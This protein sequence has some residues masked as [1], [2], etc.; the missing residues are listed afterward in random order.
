MGQFDFRENWN[1]RFGKT[2]SDQD[3]F[4]GQ[5]L[6]G[7]K[8]NPLI[9]ELDEFKTG[10]SEKEVPEGWQDPLTA[11]I[12]TSSSLSGSINTPEGTCVTS[13]DCPSGYSCIGDSCV[14]TDVYVDFGSGSNTPGNCEIEDDEGNPV[15]DVPFKCGDGGRTS[16]SN[17]GTCG[18]GQEEVAA[19]WYNSGWKA[20]Y[21]IYG[22]GCCNNPSRGI[23]IAIDEQGNRKKVKYCGPSGT[24]VG[25][26]PYCTLAAYYG[27]GADGCD[28]KACDVP[29]ES[30]LAGTCYQSSWPCFCPG[31]DPCP[32]CWQCGA[33]G[34]TNNCG[35]R[36][37]D[38]SKIDG[39]KKKVKYDCQCDCG[40]APIEIEGVGDTYDEAQANASDACNAKCEGGEADCFNYCRI[41]CHCNA[42]CP[43]GTCG[44]D[45]RCA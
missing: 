27:R 4:G 9:K 37:A 14:R 21:S 28:G 19:K 29:C 2:T 1:S 7:S 15:A 8:D 12:N 17:G 18:E 25:C 5:S 34:D 20:I 40:Q 42:D 11:D 3:E 13:T 16:C 35:S 22:G 41:E 31:A 39:C 10:D 45:A 6:D 38:G 30:C 32:D 24:Y 33:G 23:Y 36:N 44:S 26:T 43:S